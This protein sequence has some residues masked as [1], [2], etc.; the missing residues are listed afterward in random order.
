M[1]IALALSVIAIAGGALVTYLYDEGAQLASRL[2]SGACIGFAALGLFGFI[3]ASF[4]GLG[5][6]ALILSAILL[7]S[8]FALLL[9]PQLR[10]EVR[11]DFS[12]SARELR[13]AILHP[14]AQAILYFLFYAIVIVVMW[15]A[16][17]RA[18]FERP[19][20]IYTGVRNNFGDLPFHLSV[21]TRFAFGQNFPP[22]DPTYAG[23]RFT[24]PFLT[25]LVSAMFVRTG[26]NL[27]D[28]MFIEN[29]I[30]GVALVGVIHRWAFQ[31]LRDRL[32][33]VLTPILIILSGGLGWLAF[34]RDAAAS[35][36]GL[37]SLLN[38]LPYSYT[39]RPDSTWRWGNA[40]TSLLVPQRGF[41]LGI[42]LAVIVFTQWWMAGEG[43]GERDEGEKGTEGKGKRRKTKGKKH[44]EIESAPLNILDPFKVSMRRMLAAGAVAGLL[45][46]VHAHSFVV[47]M[48]IGGC[49]A[50]IQWRHWRDWLAFFLVALIIALPQMLWST[51]GSA[52]SAGSFFGWEYGW[53][54]GREDILWFWLKNTGL[55]F[56]L[57]VIGLLWKHG[58]YLVS[59]R[60]ALF[61][62]PFVLCFIVPNLFKMAPWIWDNIKVLFYWWIA[63][64]PIVAL[65]VARLWRGN[66]WRRILAASLFLALSSAGALDVF[67]LVTKQQEDRE[68]D[69]D[70]I[71]LAE[72]IRQQ[73]P[74]RAM[75][76]HAPIH[77]DPVFLTGR[78]S[79][80][81][82]PGHIWTHGIEFAP[83]EAD[84]R[85]IY[86]GGPD[87]PGLLAK[88]DV[89]YVVVSPLESSVFPV[90]ELFFEGYAKVGEAGAYRLYRITP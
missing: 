76:L 34:L 64:A 14:G 71:R 28:S 25:D 1:I 40:M 55:F 65:V 26:A 42:P 6:A 60:L 63:S 45:P 22:E 13:H 41:L 16:F 70:G 10:A 77:N 35:E 53:D 39:I 18:M 74:E 59:R 66:I 75:I 58:D 81:G 49:L 52:V 23:A 87:A 80:M 82:Y 46:L 2:C 3:T 8:P 30:V 67:A 48:A 9:K 72:M 20:G 69:R 21:I 90:N 36:R 19:D 24:Y 83:R 4:L 89:Q 38:H 51:H 47:V 79:L 29:F 12:L 68:F 56:P 11:R 54:H 78:R 50:L 85:R 5:P 88:Y 15:A 84:I 57:L 61:Y 33:A 31:L 73:T 62:L 17:S 27:R 7:A 37:F 44:H 43:D 86:A 32:A